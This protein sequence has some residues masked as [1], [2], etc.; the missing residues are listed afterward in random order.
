MK[1]Y[2]ILICILLVGCCKS[3]VRTTNGVMFV[4]PGEYFIS[5]GKELRVIE[6]A[7]HKINAY[8]FDESG[9]VLIRDMVGA[10]AYER[11]FYFWED[12]TSKLWFW[13]TDKG[14]H[15]WLLDHKSEYQR[16]SIGSSDVD[17]LP[18][19]YWEAMPSVIKS[20]WKPE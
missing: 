20:L 13:S 2:L 8:L 5:Q 6:D 1:N 19:E 3:G 12:H 7:E 4:S 10:N 17:N 16:K 9:K 11:W 14:G 15:C 18:S